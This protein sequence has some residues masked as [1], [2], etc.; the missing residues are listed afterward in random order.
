[1]PQHLHCPQGHQW[2]QPTGDPTVAVWAICPI[3][4]AHALIEPSSLGAAPSHE[5]T[6]RPPAPSL[7]KPPVALD[8]TLT[9]PTIRP[10][11]ATLPHHAAPDAA[12]RASKQTHEHSPATA[13]VPVTQPPPPAQIPETV[14]PPMPKPKPKTMQQESDEPLSYLGETLAPPPRS[15]S[16]SKVVPSLSGSLGT[17]E[18]TLPPVVNPSVP[19]GTRKPG[20]GGTHGPHP[21]DTQQ[22]AMQSPDPMGETGLHASGKATLTHQ[23]KSSGPN[24][25]GYNII[26]ELGRG[27]MGVVYKAQHI[28]LNR[29]VALKMILSGDYAGEADL[30]RFRLEA[31]AV[32]KLQHPNI[33]QVYEINECAGKPFFCLEFVDGGPLDKKLANNP[34]PP[35][36]A[37]LIMQKLAQAMDYAHQR[38]II[39]RDLKPPNVLLTK[40]GEPKITDFGL[41]KKM[42]DID[43]NTQDGSIMGTPSYMAPEQAEGRTKEIGPAADTYS[44]GAILYEFLT[45]RAPFKGATVMDTLEQVRSQEPVPPSRLEPKTPR[46]LET[47]CLKCLQ[48]DW[49]SRYATAGELADDLGRY[50]SGE[51]ILA[52]P[53]PVWERAWKWSRRRPTAAALIGVSVLA[54]LVGVIGLVVNGRLESRRAAEETRRADA[55]QKSREDETRRANA[56]QETREKETLRADAEA[57]RVEEQK[58]RTDAETQRA[59]TEKRAK[60]KEV[61]DRIEIDKQRGIA[62]EQ[63]RLAEENAEKERLA[64][65]EA[66]KQ[67][68]RAEAN[69]KEA[70]AAVEQL[71]QIGH[72]R[73]KNEPH[74]ELVR[75][76]IL[77]MALKFHNNFL[78]VNGENPALRLETGRAQLLAGEI[79]EML[80][81]H[82][83]AVT[84][85]LKAQEYFTALLKD[86]PGDA[87][88]RQDMAATWNDLGI[89]YQATNHLKEAEDAYEKALA[90]KLELVKDFE[91]EPDYRRQL[92]NSYNGR[93]FL[94]QAQKQLPEAE[95]DYRQAL[96]LFER[97][98]ADNPLEP[99]PDGVVR[100]GGPEGDELT[101]A[102][103]QQELARS[104][105]NLGAV[106]TALA[107]ER[108][109]PPQ[110]APKEGWAGKAEKAYGEALK[111]L[112]ALVVRFPEVPYYQQQVAATYLN[113][114]TLYHFSARA[115]EALT[116][117][118]E[119][120]KRFARLADQYRSVPDYRQLLSNTYVNLGQLLRAAKQPREA[121]KVW[122]QSIPVLATLALDMPKETSYRQLL[123]RSHIELAIALSTQ[124]R[125]AEALVSFADSIKILEQLVLD[126]PKNPAYWQ[127]LINGHN[128]MTALLF[129]LAPSPESEAA[130][131]K[132]VAAH[133]RRVAAFPKT[134]FYLSKQADAD[135]LLSDV[136]LDRKNPAEA[137]KALEK[138]VSHGREA[139]ESSPQTVGYRRE[140]CVNAAVLIELLLGQAEHAEAA[141]VV[142]ELIAV[143][144]PD[145]KIAGSLPPER[146]AAFLA[147]CAALVEKDEKVP[148]P[149]RKELQQEYG[150]EAMKQLKQAVAQGYTDAKVLKDAVD[151][152][153]LRMRED[154]QQ[155]LREL[156]K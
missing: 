108:A 62:L 80:G 133:E 104:H 120:V 125:H 65:I 68:D 12:P 38:K 137:R 97:L 127:D 129:Q 89:V 130:A 94:R 20:T 10:G 113:R 39:H 135:R 8:V 71:T 47:I 88:Y 14:A 141:R 119:S 143:V 41:A 9:P 67:R 145:R 74:M 121:E 15:V 26:G 124:N 132:L 142:R 102:D 114:A 147:K 72:N 100:R 144:P 33:V 55:E 56:E 53:T 50:L 4:G 90:L 76:D 123:G 156:G 109:A 35:R 6:L 69:F 57:Q 91:N 155:M 29:L 75:H 138:A 16:G 7:K 54:V 23:P 17:S 83:P 98:V 87:R 63:K 107:A 86:K 34:Q 150:D 95:A 51:P 81:R 84:A 136:L 18:E 2:E 22:H 52:R 40:D 154:F 139:L 5:E 60:E 42:D 103:F 149:K 85:Y 122:R 61:K 117:Y 92:G 49:K 66:D 112:N 11:S 64:K 13:D 101:Q 25:P 148:E 70:R 1:M 44:L 21:L 134:A 48:K 96:K 115:N 131:H 128:N 78:R 19:H 93:G 31:E 153:P 73:L 82:E 27:G 45:G 118:Q 3:C 116:D 79:E 99:L 32:A 46:D 43:G 111:L 28:S 59:D 126:E 146:V 77:E 152:A 58:R 151:F 105:L 106:W 36:Q 24:I 110:D 30:V 37:A 140:L